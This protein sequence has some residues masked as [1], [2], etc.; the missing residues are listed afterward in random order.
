[1]PRIS[2]ERTSSDTS[3]SAVPKGSGEASETRSSA[4]RTSPGAAAERALARGG[5]RPIMSR[6]RSAELAVAGSAVPATRPSRSTV[7]RW[8]SARI[9]S[10]LWLMNRIAQPSAASARSVSNS[11]ATPCG[12][13]T[14]V[15]SSMIRSRGDCRSARTISTRWRSPTESACTG[16]SGSSGRPKRSPASRIRRASASRG[17]GTASATF[18]AT[19]SVSNSE[20][21]WYTVPMPSARA[22]A[23]LATRTGSPRQRIAP[24]SGR[25]APQTSFVSVD[26]PAPFSPSSAWISPARTTRSTRSLASVP[27]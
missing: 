24:A 18:S 1:M 3:R 23:G 13:S 14:E 4:R 26:F 15:G 5:S 27:G 17:P 21:C 2:P 22:S 8:Q 7:A 19:V 25:V 16:A 10:S 12:G 20:K 9:S 11:G 6:A